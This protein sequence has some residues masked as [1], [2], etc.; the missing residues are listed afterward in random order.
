MLKDAALRKQ[1]ADLLQGGN[2]HITMADALKNFPVE[3]AGV[4]PAG[5]P[6]SAWELLEHLRIAQRDIVAFSGGMEYVELKWPDDYWPAAPG[7]GSPQ[8]WQQSVEAIRRDLDRFV[9][10][11]N[12]DTR[13]LFAPFPWGEGQTLLREALLIADHN[14]YHLGQLMLVRRELEASAY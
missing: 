14:A 5:A 7:P 3:R 12:D 1:L 11:L 10:L 2:A 9:E 4:R 8:Q 6:H 13:D